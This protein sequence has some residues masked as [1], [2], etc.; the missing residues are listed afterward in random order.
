MITIL[1]DGNENKIKG[2]LSDIL[3]KEGYSFSGENL[4][5]NNVIK[6]VNRENSQEVISLAEKVIELEESLINEK[7]GVIYK[8]VLEVIEKPLI[9]HTLKLTEGNQVKAAK[10][11]GINRN[12]VRAKVKKLGIN[13]SQWKI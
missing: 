5:Q 12:T 2:F 1:I 7:K 6:I 13:C 8:S 3:K 10:V 11:L 4:S 9:E